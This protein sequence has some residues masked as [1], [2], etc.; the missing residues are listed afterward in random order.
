MKL[1]NLFTKVKDEISKFATWAPPNFMTIVIMLATVMLAFLGLVMVS[2]LVGFWAN[3][4]YATTF[5]LGSCWQGITVVITGLG[6]ISALAKA[7]LD[8][9]STDSQY[10][11]AEGEHPYGP[12]AD[13]IKH[14][15]APIIDKK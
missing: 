8:K 3:A 10:N 4:L 14:M 15:V 1:P 9:Y 13:T 12:V 7:G 2:W 6:G 11:S 5:D